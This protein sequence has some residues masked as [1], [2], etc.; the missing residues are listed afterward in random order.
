M[1]D[2]AVQQGDRGTLYLSL[3]TVKK[4]VSRILA[5][6]GVP[7]AG[8][9]RGPLPA[10]GHRLA[11]G[12]PRAQKSTIAAAATAG[13]SHI[14]QCPLPGRVHIPLPSRSTTAGVSSGIV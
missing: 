1:C 4:Y 8:G 3:D 13:C 7:V 5:A 6:T 14:H 12:Q 9:V 11:A 10:P 2:G